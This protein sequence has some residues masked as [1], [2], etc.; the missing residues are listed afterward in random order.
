MCLLIQA[1]GKVVVKL[2]IL[3]EDINLDKYEEHVVCSMLLV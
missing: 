1:D 2:E 3:A